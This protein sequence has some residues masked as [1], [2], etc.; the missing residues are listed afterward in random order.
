MTADVVNGG[1][2]LRGICPRSRSTAVAV[3]VSLLDARLLPV[4]GDLSVVDGV[5][6]SEAVPGCE[7]ILV[8][9]SGGSWAS[10]RWD[11]QVA[12]WH[13]ES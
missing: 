3:D 1:L 13:S 8:L 7:P 12:G 5:L 6:F 2:A 9:Y 10:G 11:T 4:K